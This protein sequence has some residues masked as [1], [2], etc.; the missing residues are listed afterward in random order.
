MFIVFIS[1][2]EYKFACLDTFCNISLLQ[3]DGKY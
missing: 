2:N 3:S 1:L